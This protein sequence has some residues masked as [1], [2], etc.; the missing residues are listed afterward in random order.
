MKDYDY[1]WMPKE[2]A[3][4][5][6]AQ[7]QADGNPGDPIAPCHDCGID[8]W[9][10]EENGAYVSEDFYVSNELWD[11]TFPEDDVIRWTTGGKEFGQGQYFLCIGC[12]EL[13]IGCFERRLG[14]TLTKHDL[15]AD[16]EPPGGVS[17]RFRERW[18]AEQSH[19]VSQQTPPV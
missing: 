19:A 12:F 4:R 17:M 5:C 1:S 3:R 2:A 7:D 16:G 18:S 13:C 14:R 15:G 9:H 11:E 10:F 8:A 6:K